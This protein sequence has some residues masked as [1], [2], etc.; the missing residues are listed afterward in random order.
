MRRVA[1]NCQEQVIPASRAAAHPITR[2]DMLQAGGIGLLGLSMA[3]VAVLRS[4]A[5]AGDGAPKPRA[6]IFIFLTGG[7]SQ[8]DTFDMKPHGPAEF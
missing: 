1:E 3:D 4:A 6:V 5:V 2:R 7:P 8:H